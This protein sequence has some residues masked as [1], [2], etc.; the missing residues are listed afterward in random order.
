MQS[1]LERTKKALET[2]KQVDLDI[3]VS[4]DRFL[5]DVSGLNRVVSVSQLDYILK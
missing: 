2:I 4:V 1:Q 3:E 5:I